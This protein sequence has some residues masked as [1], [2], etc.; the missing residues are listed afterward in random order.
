MIQGTVERHGEVTLVAD[1]PSRGMSAAAA[2]AWIARY[3]RIVDGDG[4][5]AVIRVGDRRFEVRQHVPGRATVTPAD[6]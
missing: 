5:G 2:A 1:I 6:R 4:I 3:H